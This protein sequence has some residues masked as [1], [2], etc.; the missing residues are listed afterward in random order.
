MVSVHAHAVSDTATLTITG[1]VLANTCTLDSG[2]VKQSI[3]LDDIADRD[4]KGRGVTGG[5]KNIAITLTNCGSAATRVLV[6]ASG[7]PD[8]DN[9]AAFANTLS[10]ASNGATG[11]A[12]Y[13]FQTDG[14]TK[15][16]P[17]GAVTQIST[18]KPLV[19]NILTYSASYVSTKDVVT[20]GAFSTVVN[21]TFDY[22]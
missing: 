13:F 20:A 22:Q 14:T 5:T 9:S 6:T 17:A 8:D 16:D 7:T 19:D 3:K 10:K 15:F 4:I 11:V 2:S 12:L 1:T 21:M 18:L